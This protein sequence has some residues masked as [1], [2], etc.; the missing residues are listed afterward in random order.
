MIDDA[1]KQTLTS[2]SSAGLEFATPGLARPTNISDF[3]RLAIEIGL[4]TCFKL[5][6]TKCN[7]IRYTTLK[8]YCYQTNSN[9]TTHFLTELQILLKVFSMSATGYATDIHTIF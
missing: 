2:M 5:I 6:N 1:N 8:A 3:T 9:I 7:R 4:L